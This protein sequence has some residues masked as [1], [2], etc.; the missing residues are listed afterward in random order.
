MAVASGPGWAATHSNSLLT[1]DGLSLTLISARTSSTCS[2]CPAES[3]Y[4]TYDAYEVVQAQAYSIPYMHH[5]VGERSKKGAVLA[6]TVTLTPIILWGDLFFLSKWIY[7][8]YKKSSII[9]NFVD[10][11]IKK[12]YARA[13]ASPLTGSERFRSFTTI[14]TTYLWI[15]RTIIL[16]CCCCVS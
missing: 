8:I 3:T 11:C 15:L 7:G 6:V 14:D 10:F 1:D 16:L 9:R 12:E 2:S 4:H 13:W 5:R